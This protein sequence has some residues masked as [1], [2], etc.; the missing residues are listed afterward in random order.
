MPLFRQTQQAPL[1][2]RVEFLR[3]K[4]LTN[5]EMDEAFRQVGMAPVSTALTA[6]AFTSTESSTGMGGAGDYFSVPVQAA[7]Q[8]SYHTPQQSYA[9]YPYAPPPPPPPGT[10]MERDWRDWFVS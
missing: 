7:Q 2:K 9:P 6:P 10:E 1:D 8:P 5:E 4:G 3:T